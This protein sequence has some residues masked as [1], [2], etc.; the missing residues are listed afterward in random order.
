[1]KISPTPHIYAS[2]KAHTAT[3]VVYCLFDWILNELRPAPLELR[4]VVSS[5]RRM[6][7]FPDTVARPSLCAVDLET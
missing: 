3:C 6:K 4:T 2:K 1:M 7:L 5:A